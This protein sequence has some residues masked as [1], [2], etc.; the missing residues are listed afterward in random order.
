MITQSTT[1]LMQNCL[2]RIRG[3]ELAARDQ[4]IAYCQNR[5]YMLV[6]RMMRGYPNVKLWEQT[7]DVVQSVLLL[8]NTALQ[9]VPLSTV[10]DFLQLAAYHTRHV[11]IDLA[12]HYKNKQMP[13]SYGLLSVGENSDPASLVQWVNLHVHLAQLPQDERILF[14][15]LYYEGITQEE[16][17][18]LLGVSLKTLKRRWKIARVGLSRWLGDN[19]D[20]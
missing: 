8:L 15:L 17:A 16:A 20:F 13:G 4:I 14:D 11:L 3:G 5:L 6:R 10:S 19:F 9:K 18:E 1:G 12:R 7:S 2:D